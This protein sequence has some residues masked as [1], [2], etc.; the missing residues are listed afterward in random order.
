MQMKSLPPHYLTLQ[1]Q[2]DLQAQDGELKKKTLFT[3]FLSLLYSTAEYC[4]TS[5]CRNGHT[6]L[7][8]SAFNKT[9][10]NSHGMALFRSNKPLTSFL[11]HSIIRVPSIIVTLSMANPGNLDHNHI[12]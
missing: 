3:A 1:C 10:L 6:Q 9:L 7:I 11:K 8:D 2:G 4:A 5:W 12:L